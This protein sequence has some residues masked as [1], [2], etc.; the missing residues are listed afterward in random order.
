MRYDRGVLHLERGGTKLAQQV[1][2]RVQR[3]KCLMLL[4]ETAA[5]RDRDAMLYRADHITLSS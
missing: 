2:R 1:A 4:V 5:R 3:E